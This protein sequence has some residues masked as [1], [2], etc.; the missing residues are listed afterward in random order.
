MN[1]WLCLIV[2][3]NSQFVKWFD[4]LFRI[5]KDAT[6]AL[7]ENSSGQTA[8]EVAM[9]GSAFLKA[10]FEAT[11]MVSILVWRYV[12]KDEKWDVKIVVKCG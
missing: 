11:A 12:W 10:Q 4:A 8:A 2:K 7:A 1:V 6:M 5:A 9:R 3:L